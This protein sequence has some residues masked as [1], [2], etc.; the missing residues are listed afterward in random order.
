VE[1]DTLELELFGGDRL[2][3]CSDGLTETLEDDDIRELAAQ[4]APLEQICKALVDEANARG[5]PDNITVVLVG[6]QGPRQRIHEPEP[7]TGEEPEATTEHEEQARRRR[8]P[9]RAIVWSVLVVAVLVG[10]YFGVRAWV[11]RSWYVG[12]ADGNVAIFRGLPTDTAGNRLHKV[13]EVTPLPVTSV[14]PF[15]RPRLDEGIRVDSLADARKLV[16]SIPT[17][18]PSPSPKPTASRSPG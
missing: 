1:V 8:I 13:E 16:A 12:V 7:P 14:A 15:Y 17:V 6:V 11:D 4:R 2:L 3:L 10:G 9:R 18:A 5:G